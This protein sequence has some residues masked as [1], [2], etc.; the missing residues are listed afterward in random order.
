MSPVLTIISRRILSPC[1]LIVLTWHSPLRRH[2]CQFYSCTFHLISFRLHA[3]ACCM[4]S[5]CLMNTHTKLQWLHKGKQIFPSW[6]QRAIYNFHFD[7]SSFSGVMQLSLVGTI[8]QCSGEAQNGNDILQEKFQA[9][10]DNHFYRIK[11][12][13]TSA[14]HI[15]ILR[16]Y[17][18]KI[19][20]RLN[21]CS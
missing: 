8:V 1:L 3:Y 15:S 14:R 18:G 21:A 5:A 20:H 13:P 12:W 17:C 2:T 19:P 7:S 16:E 9:C 6:L 4:Y 10:S 11:S